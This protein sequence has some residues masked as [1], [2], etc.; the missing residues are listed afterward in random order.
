MSDA[1]QPRSRVESAAAP[2]GRGLTWRSLIVCLVSLLLMGV[3]NEY[4]VLYCNG[5]P[6][7]E[8]SPANSAVG[9]I[10]LVLG[11]SAVLY[12]FRRSLRLGTAELVVV[13]SALI[14]AAPLMTQGLWHRLFGLVAAIP[15]NADFKSYESLPPMLWP[16]GPNLIPDGRFERGLAECTV[17][18]GRVEWDSVEWRGRKWRVPVLSNAGQTNTSASM[19][20]RIPV[21]AVVPGE[22]FLF[23]CLVRAR[24]FAGDSAYAVSLRADDAAPVPL[25]TGTDTTRPSLALPSG[26]Q[27]VGLSP[28]V[29]PSSL[30]N[31]LVLTVGLHGQGTLA[32]HDLQFFDVEAVEGLYAG[33]HVIRRSQLDTLG[34]HERNFT[35]VRP[36]NLFSFAGLRYLGSGGIPLRAWAQPALAWTMLVG[37]LFA[38]FFGLNVLMRK[39]WVEYERFTFPLTIL[40]KRLLQVENGRLAIFRN[41]VMWAGFVV[42]FVLTI[43]KGLCFYYPALPGFGFGHGSFAD[44]VDNPVLKAFLSEVSMDGIGLGLGLTFCLLAVVLLIETDVLFSLWLTFFVFQLWRAFGKA[45]N[46][47]RYA[48]Y[49]W[50]HQQT[51]GGFIAFA[52]LALFV[53][54]HHLARVFRLIL[55]HCLP[56]E[57]R[58]AWTYRGALLLVFASL[59][60]VAGWSVWTQ[61]G[62]GAGLLFFSYMLVCG[63]AASKIRAEMGAP[64]GYLT[65]YYGMQFAAAAGGFAV[66]HSTGMLVATI[67]SG[68]MCTSCFLLMAPAQ[69]EMMELGR[70]FNVRPRDIGAGLTLGLLGGLFIGG[71]VV[72][73]WAYGFGANNLKVSFPYELN[74]YFNGFRAAELNADRAFEAGVLGL[75]ADGQAFNIIHNPDAKGL[76]IGAGI[77][78]ALAALRS[79]FT[80]FPLH[81]LG[82][83]LASTFF[84]KGLWLYAFLAWAI[85]L[86]LFRMGGARTIRDGLVPFCVGLFLAAVTSIVVFDIVGIALRLQGVTEVYAGMP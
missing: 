22:Q 41:R 24:D 69:V 27:R 70:H 14:L 28:V 83:V 33:R 31:R 34:P 77:T 13:Y 54:R 9:V 15:H 61:M 39:Q 43:W 50:E 56:A 36:D 10:L 2:Q 5:G 32:M 51:M 71:F 4:E 63:F 18:G 85:R 3:W 19:T 45:F 68:F 76:A 29:I 35:R 52:V 30:T 26:L 25:L 67:A 82:Y 16:H 21:S 1:G 37:A 79:L 40:P 59:A 47:T 42:A 46:L 81:P 84:M 17:E 58:E 60:A 78:F 23:S 65:P 73:S 8:N 49:P 48:G 53:G 57:R 75:N 20:F 38:G 7:A 55:G 86:A 74:W 64:M 62:L 66:F 80:W 44:Y 12:R 6:L 72:L 11:L